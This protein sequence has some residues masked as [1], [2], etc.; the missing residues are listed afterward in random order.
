MK[1]FLFILF[2]LAAVS[3][4]AQQDTVFM[5]LLNEKDSVALQQKLALLG[6]SKVEK[7]LMSLFSYYYMK[8]NIAMRDSIQNVAIA[9]YPRGR[10]AANKMIMQMMQETDVVKKENLL[11]QYKNDFPDANMDAA[12]SAMV[13]TMAKKK[14]TSEDAVKYLDMIKNRE[15]RLTYSYHLGVNIAQHDPL[16]GEPFLM[17]KIEEFKDIENDTALIQ[18]NTFLREMKYAYGKILF[19]RGEYRQAL[20]LLKP[21]YDKATDRYTDLEKKVQYARVLI[22]LEDYQSAFPILDKLVRDGKGNALLKQELALVYSKVYPDKDSA[23]YVAAIEKEVSEQV[24][25]DYLKHLI[26]K[27]APSFTVTDVN[28]EEVTLDG[29]SGKTIIVDFWAT[30]CVPC[31]KSF[32]AMQ[33]AVNKYKNDPDVKFLFIHTWEQGTEPLKDARDYLTENHYTFDLYIDP[34]DDPEKMNT[35]KTV[36]LFGVKSIPQKFVINSKGIIRF[37]V[38]GF[39]GGDDAAVEELTNMIEYCKKEEGK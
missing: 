27:P 37:Q 21:A 33:L 39:H 11:A 20:P 14:E 3:A 17:H 32:P 8:G 31:K 22:K 19:D 6:S 38:S 12:Y 15:T 2:T 7:D 18:Q 4:G 25:K 34:R 9:L 28:G 36:E 23:A 13:Y 26:N 10:V 5:E 29:F 1:K 35:N 16:R 30:W 24:A